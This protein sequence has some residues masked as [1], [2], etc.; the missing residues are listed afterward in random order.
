MKAHLFGSG[1]IMVEVLL[2]AQLLEAAGIACDVWSAT[3]YN[4]LVRDAQA[5]QRRNLLNADQP[6][7]SCYVER[8]LAGETGVFVAAS[9]YMKSV[10]GRIAQWLP[11]PFAVLGTDGFGLSEARPELRE[12]FEVNAGWIADS[13]ASLLVRQ[14]V[15]PANRLTELRQCWHST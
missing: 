12:Y 5:V 14:G 2:A 11:G 3:S 7:E 1:A 8:L 15:L 4:C 10:P 13:A 6:A 9:D